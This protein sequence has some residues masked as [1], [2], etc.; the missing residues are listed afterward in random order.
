MSDFKLKNGI[1]AL[2]VISM[3]VFSSSIFAQSGSSTT[4]KQEKGKTSVSVKDNVAKSTFQRG[5]RFVDAN[6]DGV[7]D[8]AQDPNFK[9]PMDGSGRKNGMGK[10][11]G[12][13]LRGQGQGT[14]TGV[15]DGTGPKGRASAK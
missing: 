4:G 14:G 2:F 3:L 6:G 5:P 8:N 1:I 9:R 7:C 13:G 12:M 11:H 15:C 10:G